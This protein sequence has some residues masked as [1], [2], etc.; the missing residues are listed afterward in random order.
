MTSRILGPLYN[1]SDSAVATSD[2][3]CGQVGAGDESDGKAIVGT[4]T[5]NGET[6]KKE[7]KRKRKN[8]RRRK[9]KVTSLAAGGGGDQKEADR[10]CHESKEGL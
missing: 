2:A 3:T 6:A 9:N 5:Q 8:K 1:C 7:G 4:D 10:D